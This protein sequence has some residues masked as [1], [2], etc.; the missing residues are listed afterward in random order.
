M[1]LHSS[2]F[3]YFSK[4]LEGDPTTVEAEYL[5][6]QVLWSSKEP[7]QRPA[8][9]LD[10]LTIANECG[11]YPCIATLLRIFATLPVTTSTSERSFSALKYIKN[12][13]RSTMSDTR[14][15]GL[16]HLYINRD[17][18]LNYDVV[19]DEFGKKNRRLQFQ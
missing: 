5:R 2:F 8:R 7:A 19:V 15:N 6:W 16:A 12:Y 14:L 9:V 11:T 4:F 13:L 3:D 17:I 1:K 10:A 18:A